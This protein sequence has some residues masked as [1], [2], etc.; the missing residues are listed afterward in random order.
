MSLS[1]IWYTGLGDTIAVADGE[2]NERGALAGILAI[3]AAAGLLGGLTYWAIAGRKAGTH[4][5][6]PTRTE[7]NAN[8]QGPAAAHRPPQISACRRAS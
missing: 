4:A 6:T 5:T 7:G 3:V 2:F 8:A 1:S